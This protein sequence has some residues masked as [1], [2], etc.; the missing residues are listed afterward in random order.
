[1]SSARLGESWNTGTF[2]TDRR[3]LSAALKPEHHGAVEQAP[4]HNVEVITVGL[5]AVSVE[6]SSCNERSYGAVDKY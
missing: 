1:M 4:K 5:L 6:V 3:I 2:D